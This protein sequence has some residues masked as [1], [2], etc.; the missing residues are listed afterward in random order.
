M[1]KTF[2]DSPPE[3]NLIE[4]QNK[5]D[6]EIIKRIPFKMQIQTRIAFYTGLIKIKDWYTQHKT[7]IELLNNNKNI[8]LAMCLDYMTFLAILQ[9]PRLQDIAVGST[10]WEWYTTNKSCKYNLILNKSIIFRTFTKNKA[11]ELERQN[12]KKIKKHEPLD[13]TD[14]EALYSFLMATDE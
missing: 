9:R 8:F 3:A 13:I 11:I 2:F 12:R 6:P 14:P 4:L 1:T 5:I 10:Q 7:D